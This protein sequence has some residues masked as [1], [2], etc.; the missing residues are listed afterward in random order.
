[1]LPFSLL[2][3]NTTSALFVMPKTGN[4]P[5]IFQWEKKLNV[6]YAS[7]RIAANHKKDKL[8]T[9]PKIYESPGNHES[10]KSQS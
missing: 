10:E 7:Y 4:N 8:L 6:L 1:M 3:I 9:Y 5:D 2:C